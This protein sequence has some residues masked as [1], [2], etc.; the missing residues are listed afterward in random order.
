MARRYTEEENAFLREFIP[1]H[2]E[3]EIADAFEERFGRRLTFPQIGNRKAALGVR[4]G[5]VGGR[6]EKGNVPATKGRPWSE[7]MPPESQERS[8][9]T[10]FRKGQLPHNTRALLDERIGKDG[11]VQVHIGQLRTSKPNDQWMSKAQFVWERENGTAWPEGCR[12]MFADGDR[13]NF[14]PGNI[15]PVPNELYAVVC[16][17]VKG[18][19]EWHDR[20]SLE[21]AITMA[22]IIRARRRLEMGAG[23]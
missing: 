12:A 3:C 11:Y 15:V 10:Q 2:S 22:R 19:L 7:W 14:D 5:T 9:A 13:L 6:F 4:S 21:A 23:A 20:E 8:R 1:G 18:G 16:G 17:A